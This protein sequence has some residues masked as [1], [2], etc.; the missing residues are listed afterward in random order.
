M[1]LAFELYQ[2]LPQA[3]A[4]GARAQRKRARRRFVFYAVRK[5]RQPGVFVGGTKASHMVNFPGAKFKGFRTLAEDDS[6]GDLD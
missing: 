3:G 6:L 1:R 4:I 5:G 2:R